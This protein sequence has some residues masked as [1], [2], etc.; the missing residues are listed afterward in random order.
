MV[1]NARLKLL[2]TFIFHKSII[3]E[4]FFKNHY[5]SL[6][7]QSKKE[8][9]RHNFFHACHH[10]KKSLAKVKIYRRIRLIELLIR[11][12]QYWRKRLRIRLLK[13][14]HNFILEVNSRLLFTVCFRKI[15]PP[16]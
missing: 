14:L 5:H 1:F 9:F 12:Q 2:Y 3:K 10:C 16:R 13:S 8:V 11:C 7:F 15:V 4:R 6:F